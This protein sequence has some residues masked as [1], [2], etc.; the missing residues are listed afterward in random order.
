ML[1]W[2]F[3]VTFTIICL[4]IAEVLSRRIRSEHKDWYVAGAIAVFCILFSYCTVNYL[5]IKDYR[6]FSEG[7][8]IVHNMKSAAELG[9]DPPE[10]ANEY[11]LTN[12]HTNKDSLILSNWWLKEQGSAWFK[13]NYKVKTYEGREVKIKDGYEPPIKDF[14]LLDLYGEEKTQELLDQKGYTLVIVSKDMQ[15]M[16]DEDVTDLVK[17]TNDFKS[18]GHRAVALVAGQV[19]TKDGI[20]AYQKSS[21]MDIPFYMA[22]NI[23]LKTMIRSNPGIILL[24]DATVLRK[25]SWKALPDYEDIEFN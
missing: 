13:R 8:D 11:T 1:E 7:S 10:Y 6:G 14:T 16:M 9:L 4:I 17:L 15:S 25:W 3:P 12:I 2:L 19:A 5:P 24:K 21:G 18:N 23:V 20:L 22:D